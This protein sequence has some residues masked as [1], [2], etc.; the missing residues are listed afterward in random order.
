MLACGL[1]VQITLSVPLTILSA[2]VAVLFT[3]FAF[4]SGEENSPIHTRLA[5]WIRRFAPRH[6]RPTPD[7]SEDN[8]NDE[9]ELLRDNDHNAMA[10]ARA[11][12]EEAFPNYDFGPSSRLP[13]FAREDLAYSTSQN[14]LPSRT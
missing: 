10:N 3:F 4:L 5:S 7:N 11:L 2:V 12:D 13:A 6:K 14:G 1:D 9:R 8:D